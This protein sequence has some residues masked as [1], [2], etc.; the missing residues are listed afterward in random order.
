MRL[1]DSAAKSARLQLALIATV[2]F[3]PLLAAAWMYYGG[4]FDASRGS[5]HGALLQPIVK[6]REAL[7]DSAM[8][9]QGEGRWMLLFAN[10][11]YCE[12]TCRDALNTLRQGRLMLGKEQQRLVRGFL[13]GDT[14]PDKVFLAAEHPGLIITQDTRLADLLNKNKPGQLA[15][16]GYFLLDPLGNL[17]MYFRPDIDPS[18]MVADIEH[19][20]RLSHI[21]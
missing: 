4:H 1:T 13:H 17:V 21:G 20:L 14:A 6:L 7:P 10:D 3:G 18:D 15:A 11:S 5:N 8:L 16:G 9:I 12:Q 19:L 2:F